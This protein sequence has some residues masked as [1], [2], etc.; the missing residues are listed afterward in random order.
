MRAL[1]LLV[2]LIVPLVAQISLPA[3]AAP[4]VCGNQPALG[5]FDVLKC[6]VLHD[7]GVAPDLV[8][9]DGLFSASVRLDP[10]TLLRYKIL[11]TGDYGPN[12][13]RLVGSCGPS[14]EA[15]SPTGDILVPGPDISQPVLFFYD[16]RAPADPTWAAPPG[17]RSGG[18]SVMAAAPKDR[19]PS[20]IAIGDFEQTPFDPAGGIELRQ[21]GDGAL[22]GETTLTRD[23]P[24]GWQWKVFEKGRAFAEAG[25]RKFGING[26]SYT[27]TCDSDNAQVPTAAVTGSQLRFTFYPQRGRLRT[28]VQAPCCA[29]GAGPPDQ[30]G[31]VDLAAAPSDQAGPQDLQTD[32]ELP[33][34]HCNCRVVRGGV[35][36]PGGPTLLMLTALTALFLRRAYRRRHQG[37]TSPARDT[38]RAG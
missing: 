16:S 27:R 5:D 25:A 31:L 12:D 13:I 33:G 15:E 32:G 26:W 21:M 34:I 4:K 23:L 9:G 10:T 37:P 7:D 22:I 29:D 14:A 28:E 24:A 11:P 30:R 2:A 20:W 1:P 36:R 6:P 19:T 35:R 18:D 38:Q 17:N 8:S 3:A